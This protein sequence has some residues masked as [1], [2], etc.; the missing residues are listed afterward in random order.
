MGR[1]KIPGRE[2]VNFW[3]PASLKTAGKKAAKA[4]G[5]SF[6]DLMCELLARETGETYDPQEELPLAESA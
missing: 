6:T 1:K 4:R 2:Q 5:K 3:A